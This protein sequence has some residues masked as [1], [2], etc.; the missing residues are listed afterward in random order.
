MNYK[1]NLSRPSPFLLTTPAAGGSIAAVRQLGS[2]GIPI[3]IAG[4]ER[5]AAARWSRYATQFLRCPS[6]QDA[7]GFLE[8]LIAFGRR[9]PGHVLYPTS[10]ETV[11][12]FASNEAV[13]KPYFKMYQ[14]PL[15]SALEAL[16]KKRF[17]Q[18]CKRAQV[19]TAPSWFPTNEDELRSLAPSLP[20]PILIKPRTHVHRVRKDK[21]LVAHTE[22]ALLS[23]YRTIEERERYLAGF[24]P[25]IETASRPFLQKFA[26]RLN[27]PVYSVAGFIER[28]SEVIVARG[29]AKILQRW[30]PPAIGVCFEARPIEPL[31][32]EAVKRLCH[33]IGYF[34]VFEAEFLQLDGTW[35]AIDFNPRFYHQ[36]GLEISGGLPLPLLVYLAACDEKDALRKEMTRAASAPDIP[37]LVSCDRF[38]FWTNL[39]AMTLTGRAGEA[40]W[41][42]WIRWHK[43]H[44]VNAVD[45]AL[46]ARDPLPAF[47]HAVSEIGLGFKALSRLMRGSIGGLQSA[48]RVVNKGIRDGRS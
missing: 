6:V 1:T 47:A 4:N 43:D 26:H 13:L 30:R 12:L 14:P 8:W 35:V 20:Y 46:D 41:F 23:T 37:T 28:G 34:G 29:S 21:G 36:M 11:W 19:E 39:A 24:G 5:L 42:R 10:D 31:L 44:H 16:D 25:T 48:A 2:R 27:D 22:D 7:D 15:Q 45:I 18:A 32:F 3:T 33:E 9:N 40:E 17:W 38:T